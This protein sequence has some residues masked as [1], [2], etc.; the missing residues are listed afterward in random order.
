MAL[1][2]AL[3]ADVCRLPVYYPLCQ[4]GEISDEKVAIGYR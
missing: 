2:E 3:N 4:V 1:L